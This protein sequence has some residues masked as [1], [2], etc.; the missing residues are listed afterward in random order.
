MEDEI[1]TCIEPDGAARRRRLD[2]FRSKN[3][4]TRRS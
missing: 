2:V 3:P 1:L 4:V